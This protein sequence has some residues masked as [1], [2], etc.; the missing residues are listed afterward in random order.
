MEPYTPQKCDDRMPLLHV[1]T[2]PMSEENGAYTH[3][4]RN[5]N[6]LI[7]TLSF[8]WVP[9]TYDKIR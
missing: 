4:S 7:G 9:V 5:C 1:D 2:P 3:G 8:N 6:N